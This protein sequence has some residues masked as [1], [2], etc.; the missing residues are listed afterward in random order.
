MWDKTLLLW[1]AFWVG[2]RIANQNHKLFCFLLIFANLSFYMLQRIQ[3]LHNFA[4]MLSNCM[5][6]VLLPSPI[7]VDPSEP[8]PPLGHGEFGIAIRRAGDFCSS[9][10]FRIIHC[11]CWLLLHCHHFSYRIIGL[12]WVMSHHTIPRRYQSMIHYHTN[13][14]N[15]HWLSVPSMSVCLSMSIHIGPH[16]L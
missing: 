3:S 4:C 9:W 1:E 6:V 12:N 5:D 13:Q 15:N 16:R 10:T 11:C 2:G 8:I 14:S 7:A